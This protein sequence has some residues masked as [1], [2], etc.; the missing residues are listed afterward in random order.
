MCLLVLILHR[1]AC[2]TF[3]NNS[4]LFLRSDLYTPKCCLKVN[5]EDAHRFENF[6]TLNSFFFCSPLAFLMPRDPIGS[7]PYIPTVLSN[8][9]LLNVLDKAL[10][11]I[12]IL[13]CIKYKIL[14]LNQMQKKIYIKLKKKIKN[15]L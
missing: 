8:V 3:L 4:N 9:L 12:S 6:Y 1:F 11:Q 13:L 7:Q 15:N 5:V 14:V 2:V 10:S